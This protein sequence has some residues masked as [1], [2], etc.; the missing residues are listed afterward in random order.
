MKW[1][2]VILISI[3]MA[4]FIIIRRFAVAGIRSGGTH[5]LAS[6]R[7]SNL[8]ILLCSGYLLLVAYMT[9]VP[10][11][12]DFQYRYVKATMDLMLAERNE[13]QFARE[14]RKQIASFVNM[15]ITNSEK[16][17]A[18]LDDPD[19]KEGTVFLSTIIRDWEGAKQLTE[20]LRK[21]QNNL[22]ASIRYLKYQYKTAS[23]DDIEYA[24]TA[25]S[26][27]SEDRNEVFITTTTDEITGITEGISDATLLMIAELFEKE[28]NDE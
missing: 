27:A 15:G 25:Y 20:Q 16:L 18:N 19:I 12:A 28:G 23:R 2:M 4:S 9:V 22:G 3:V 21:T 13:E 6:K 11:L 1:E 26:N 8:I 14:A 5:S 7:F 24:T 17:L 10:V